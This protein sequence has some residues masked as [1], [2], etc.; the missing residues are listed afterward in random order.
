[1]RQHVVVSANV[2]ISH[3]SVVEDFA[4]LS[5]GVV[6]AGTVRIGQGARLEPGA[7]VIPN[8]NVG[9]WATVGPRAVV[10][11]D[12]PENAHVEGMPAISVEEPESVAGCQLS[13]EPAR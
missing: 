10:I 4:Q 3:D 13:P 1:L 9:A 8:I 2:T 12:V 5:P 6:L 11:R 7:L